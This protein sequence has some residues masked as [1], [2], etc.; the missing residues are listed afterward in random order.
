MATTRRTPLAL[1]AL[2]AA[3]L[4][5]SWNPAS[6]PLGLAVGLLAGALSL[7]AWREEGRAAP[8]IRAALVLAAVAVVVSGVVIARAA[9][10]GRGGDG[11]PLVEGIPR[12]ERTQVLD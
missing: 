5:S 1:L 4:L 7:K 3:A 10:A 12:T 8:R 2:G 11:T 6:A 9:W